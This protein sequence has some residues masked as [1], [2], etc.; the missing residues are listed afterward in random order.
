MLFSWLVVCDGS[1]IHRQTARQHTHLRTKYCN[2]RCAFMPSN[3]II[4]RSWFEVTIC[5]RKPRAPA[6]WRHK[7]SR[8]ATPGHEAFYQRIVTME[9]ASNYFSV[10]ASRWGLWVSCSFV[11]RR[12]SN[13][14]SMETGSEWQKMQCKSEVAETSDSVIFLVVHV[15]VDDSVF[16]LVV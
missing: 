5:S 10:S 15:R 4:V 6:L 3:K 11:W 8:G 9:S 12:A 13:D 2:S 7:R 16:D 1:N 14:D